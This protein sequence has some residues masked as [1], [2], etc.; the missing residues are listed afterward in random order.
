MRSALPFIPEKCWS[1]ARW[2]YRPR[3]GH[4]ILWR[5]DRRGRDD[6]RSDRGADRDLVKVW[7]KYNAHRFENVNTKTV[8]VEA[9]DDGIRHIRQ[10]HEQSTA[11][12]EA[13]RYDFALVAVGRAKRLLI[14]VTR[15]WWR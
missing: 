4:G 3:N 7:Q 11:P 10:G 9:K 14:G 8:A 1:S 6:G 12:A 15:L 5:Q 2:D 13:Q